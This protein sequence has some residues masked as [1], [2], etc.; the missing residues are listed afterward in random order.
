MGAR[1]WPHF[2]ETDQPDPLSGDCP[3]RFTAWAKYPDWQ[4]DDRIPVRLGRKLKIPVV[5]VERNRVGVVLEGGAID[6][7]GQGTLLTTEECVLDEQ[8]QVRNPGFS[9]QDYEEVFGAFRHFPG[10]LV[11][12]RHCR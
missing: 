11:R 7:N 2:R 4:L 5:P 10:S 9:R 12:T 1:L 3:F 8:V 6:V